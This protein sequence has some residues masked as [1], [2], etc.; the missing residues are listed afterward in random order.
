MPQVSQ[1]L[2]AYPAPCPQK[3]GA[4]LPQRFYRWEPA[5]PGFDPIFFRTF[6]RAAE[7]LIRC[8]KPGGITGNRCHDYDQKRFRR[9]R[10]RL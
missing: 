1:I 10:R 4:E 9:R 8:P 6:V 3:T 7:W 2:P 5:L